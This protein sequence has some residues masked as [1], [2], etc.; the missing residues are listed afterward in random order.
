MNLP[1]RIIELSEKATTGPWSVNERGLEGCRCCDVIEHPGGDVTNG[2]V[3]DLNDSHLIAEYR[4]LAPRL[5]EWARMAAPIIEKLSNS[6][7]GEG[8]DSSEFLSSLDE[9]DIEDARALLKELEVD[10]V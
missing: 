7:W 5:A 10:D 3:Y 2:G 1:D 9:Q 6:F 8:E 4:T